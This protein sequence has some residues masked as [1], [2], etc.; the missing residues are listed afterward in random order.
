MSYNLRFDTETIGGHVPFID[1]IETRFIRGGLTL[2]A[3]HAALNRWESQGQLDVIDGRLTALAG[4]IL[5]QQ[6]VNGL[7]Q[8]YTPDSAAIAATL[9][10]GDPAANAAIR[11]TADNVGQVGNQVNVKLTNPGATNQAL[12]VNVVGSSIEVLLATD[13]AGVLTS[14]ADAVFAAINAEAD[15]AALVTAALHPD[16]TNGTGIM[17]ET[18][19]FENLE[20]GA[21]AVTE[22]ISTANDVVLL[23]ENADLSGGNAVATGVCGGRVIENRLPYMDA[24]ARVAMPH[25]KILMK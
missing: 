9:D 14:D 21:E 13:G 6:G 18:D 1:T 23:F 20:G 22:N 4:A 24:V 7:W 8:V 11:I 12:T 2:D 19:A 5:A 10:I 17:Q 3:A 16:A 15:A 25:I